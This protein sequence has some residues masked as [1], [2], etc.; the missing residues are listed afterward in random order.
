MQI[1]V[2]VAQHTS[3]F[4]PDVTRATT[5]IAALGATAATVIGALNRGKITQVHT[6]VNGQ[7]TKQV[8]NLATV[9]EQ[10][11]TVTQQR[12]TAEHDLAE[13]TTPATPA[14]LEH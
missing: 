14:P 13:V 1:A 4:W 5:A 10:L 12:D 2:L 9:T 6:V 8:E 7:F 11:K 3:Q